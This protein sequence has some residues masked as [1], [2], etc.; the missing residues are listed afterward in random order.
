MTLVFDSKNTVSNQGAGVLWLL[1]D[2]LVTSCGWSVPR[3]GNGSTGGDGDNISSASD[4]GNANSW[5]VL[6]RP[7]DGA[8]WCFDRGA[9]NYRWDI[10]YSKEALFTGGNASD[11]ATATDEQYV[12]TN[13]NYTFY[14]GVTNICA[15]NA[16]PYGFVAYSWDAGDGTAMGGVIYDPIIQAYADDPDPYICGS[17][18]GYDRYQNI[19]TGDLA[20]N[21]RAKGWSGDSQWGAIPSMYYA[22][23]DG[24]VS[25]PSNVLP[26]PY[27]ATPIYLIA[28]PIHIR[29][30]DLSNGYW[31]G[32]S[33]FT[34]WTGC[35]MNELDTIT[36]GDEEWVC[37]GRNADLLLP[38]E[39]GVETASGYETFDGEYNLTFGGGST[40]TTTYSKRARDDG[41]D[42]EVFYVYWQT[43]NP[44]GAYTGTPVGT[45]QDTV[46]IGVEIS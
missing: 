38:W 11:R 20:A 39:P 31:K 14:G 43:T 6:R 46:I 26:N 17:W 45:L 15:D 40:T 28:H 37:H 18:V 7:D 32:L 29:S 16:S 27:S 36:V 1:K 2:L 19:A 21:P 4:L 22:D 33:S 5:M 35:S 25:I 24:N 42:P 13:A 23:A 8:E 34:N 44:D 41:Y 9:D 10:L 30:N 3:S 12:T